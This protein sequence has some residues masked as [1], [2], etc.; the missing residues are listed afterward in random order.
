VR[1]DRHKKGLVITSHGDEIVRVWFQH[2]VCWS[3]QRHNPDLPAA[4][5]G[6]GYLANNF[7]SRFEKTRK[8][9]VPVESFRWTTS[10]AICP[11]LQTVRNVFVSVGREAALKEGLI[12][13]D[14]PGGVAPDSCMRIRE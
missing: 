4:N 12:S 14:G 2:G 5:E 13:F 7:P 9:I 10:R 3:Q 1:I 8:F 11:Y 6:M